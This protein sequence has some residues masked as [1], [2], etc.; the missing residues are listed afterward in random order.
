MAKIKYLKGDILNSQTE[1]LVNTVNCVGVMGKGIALQFK[2]AF[3]DNFKAYAKACRYGDVLPGKMFIFENNDLSGPKYIINF[4]T[5]RHWK[6]KSR[7]EDIDAGLRSLASDIERLDIKSVA[8]P[9]L[10]SGLGG[11]SWNSVKP[12]V[13]KHFS[14]LIST[15]VDVFE[16]GFN[17]KPELHTK[18]NDEPPSL[19]RGRAL[20]IA[21]IDR[22]LLACMDTSVTLLEIH[23][24]LYLLQATGENLRLRYVKAEYGPYAENLRFVLKAM[25]NYYITGYS[26]LSE[27][28][29][30]EIEL[31]PGATQEASLLLGQEEEVIKRMDTVSGLIA[32][33]ETSFGLELLMTVHWLADRD[34]LDTAASL[35]AGV[36]TWNA[37][38]KAFSVHS[39]E[40]AIE[41][42]N[43]KRL[44]TLQ[45][46]TPPRH[47]NTAS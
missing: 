40:K 31:I 38:K 15:E 8:I 14:S 44:I 23:K 9:P 13:E 19:T 18:K 32:G 20:L 25:E 33:F 11:L 46:T 4:P 5:K 12:L 35:V 34:H 6:G 21:L 39:I 36:H 29:S 17:P 10:G 28:P 24:L 26:G 1:A 2:K 30:Q 37:R 22:Y 41:R 42:L 47:H 3:P 7:I 16:P 27:D 43:E 45:D